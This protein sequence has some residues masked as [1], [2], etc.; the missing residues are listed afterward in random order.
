M[1]GGAS[2]GAGVRTG[3]GGGCGW[4]ASAGAGGGVGSGGL[5]GGAGGS[6]AGGGVATLA[7]MAFVRSS[8]FSFR[9]DVRSAARFVRRRNS[10][11]KQVL[12]VGVAP[13]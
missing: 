1:V 6:G 9:A 3:A 2:T 10:S 13:G 4:S 5:G 7:A 12:I 8:E 11:A